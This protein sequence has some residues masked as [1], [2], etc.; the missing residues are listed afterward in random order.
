M[1]TVQ[2]SS[3]G[4]TTK[5]ENSSN[6][7]DKTESKVEDDFEILSN[8][9]NED[10]KKEQPKKE[11]EPKEESVD[12]PIAEKDEDEKFELA[13]SFDAF[14]SKDMKVERRMS[15]IKYIPTGIDVLDKV[16]GGGAS[17]GVVQFVGTPGSGKSPILAKIISNGQRLYGKKFNSVFIDS[18]ETMTKERLSQLGVNYPPLEPYQD[19]TV[20][21]VFQV[22]EGMSL[23]KQKYPELIDIPW[24]IG[25]DSIANTLSEVAMATNDVNSVIGQKARALAHF[26]PKYVPVMNKYSICLVCVNQ[27]RDKIDMGVFKQKS[28]LKFLS[29][30]KLPGGQSLLFNSIQIMNLSPVGKTVD[31]EYGFSGQRVEF[32]AIKNKLYAPNIPIK[33]VFSFENGYSNFYTNF[34]LL[35][36][37]KRIKSGAWCSLT[38]CPEVGNFRQKQALEFYKTK[39]DFRKAFDADVKDVLQTE[40][41]DIYKSTNEE[42]SDYIDDSAN[43]PTYNYPDDNDSTQELSNW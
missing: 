37:A 1:M 2:D 7:D 21:K 3:T 22:V 10:V 40:F 29:N 12:A 39:P 30:K 24:V 16:M 13:D 14:L 42:D 4:V 19:M 25:W 32:R 6:N 41:D 15:S 31:G 35:K 9:S 11:P 34:E 20:E 23:F 28:D 33:V 38:S 36:S 8:K 26:L 5:V 27:L 43:I 18:E 17:V